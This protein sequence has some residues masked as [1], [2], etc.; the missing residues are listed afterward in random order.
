M[1]EVTNHQAQ[2]NHDY[3]ELNIIPESNGD[4]TVKSVKYNGYPSHSV[5]AGQPCIRFVTTCESLKEA[6]S[7]YP[8]ATCSN[9]HL[10]PQN[11]FDHL[12]NDTDY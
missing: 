11:T 2:I 9:K 5:L 8:D 6:Q 10:M 4:F 12:P 3:D 1:K 7:A